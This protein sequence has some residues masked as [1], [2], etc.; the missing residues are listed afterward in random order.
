M[1][2]RHHARFLVALEALEQLCRD[3]LSA[4]QRESYWQACAGAS[5]LEE[6]EAATQEAM[7]QVTDYRVPLPAQLV[8][9]VHRQRRQQR[10]ETLLAHVPASSRQSLLSHLETL[11]QTRSAAPLWA[12]LW[13][14]EARQRHSVIAPLEALPA[15]DHPSPHQQQ[16]EDWL[17]EDA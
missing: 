4:E 5:S 10:T 11:R 16:L 14:E 6:W 12:F 15:N 8:A 9:I 3:T 1:T 17:E 7:R 2:E 13:P